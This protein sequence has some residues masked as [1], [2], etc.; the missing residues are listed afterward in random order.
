M[1]F[2]SLHLAKKCVGNVG[3]STVPVPWILW[4]YIYI[5][6]VRIENCGDESQ[7]LKVASI[8]TQNMYIYIYIY[9][10]YNIYTIY[11]LYIYTIYILY[12]YY[13][14]IYYIYAVHIYLYIIY[15]PI[16]IYILYKYIQ[17]KRGGLFQNPIHGVV[18]PTRKESG[19]PGDVVCMENLSVKNL[20][21]ATFL[22]SLHG[23]T[24]GVLCMIEKYREMMGDASQFF[25]WSHPE[26]Y[27]S[28]LILTA[29]VWNPSSSFLLQ[30][31]QYIE[32]RWKNMLTKKN[33]Q[34]CESS[35]FC[36]Y[37]L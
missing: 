1:V 30:Q 13:I 9:I 12:I 26:L 20:E 21:R 17:E 25:F 27:T 33:V 31:K 24:F 18:S 28:F 36:T 11:I 3:K 5:Y 37:A 14:Y 23:W 2:Y 4:V 6:T 22:T 35:N 7:F 10:L 15:I 32:R 29:S 8:T 19:D 16:Y 34:S